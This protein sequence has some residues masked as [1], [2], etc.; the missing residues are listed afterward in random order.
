MYF[1]ILYVACNSLSYVYYLNFGCFGYCSLL[2]RVKGLLNVVTFI[3]VCK[4]NNF[5]KLLILFKI[6]LIMREGI[7]AFFS[8]R[9]GISYLS[10]LCHHT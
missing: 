1:F 4:I 2:G 3:Y 7:L 8:V 9:V 5:K 10:Y 6:I